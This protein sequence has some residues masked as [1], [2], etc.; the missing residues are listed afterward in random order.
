MATSRRGTQRGTPHDTSAMQSPMQ[1]ANVVLAVMALLCT[2]CGA[3]VG[4]HSWP[5]CCNRVYDSASARCNHAQVHCL[6][7]DGDAK[8]DILSK[9]LEE[10][11]VNALF[12]WISQ[13]FAGDERYNNLMLAFAAIFGEDSR[14]QALVASALLKLPAE[15][16]EIGEPISL[17]QRE[18]G[19]LGAMGAGQWT[20]QFRTRPHALL[21][22]RSLTS[23]GNWSS[24]LSRGARRTLAKA[25]AQDFE[26]IARPIR[27]DQPAPHSTLAHFRCVVEHE[28]RLL[29]DTPEELLDALSQA[30]SRCK[31]PPLGPH[32]VGTTAS[33]AA[34]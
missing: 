10:K 12:A 8:D 19:S 30:I 27:G 33:Q 32:R 2:S 20:G 7:E 15:D 6:A 16:E 14:L 23:V 21:D 18:R 1:N 4:P 9:M 31:P 22:V 3:F 17:Q 13:A 28:V 25:A 26:V 34:C 5:S 11:K 29:A 24:S